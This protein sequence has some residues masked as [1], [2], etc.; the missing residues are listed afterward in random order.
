[1]KKAK[2]ILSVANE[3]RERQKQLGRRTSLIAIS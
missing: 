2:E 3:T 1:M